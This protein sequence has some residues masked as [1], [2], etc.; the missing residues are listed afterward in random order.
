MCCISCCM[1]FYLLAEGC[2]VAGT[3]AHCVISSPPRKCCAFS[4][5]IVSRNPPRAPLEVGVLPHWLVVDG[6]QPAIPENAPVERP[7]ARKR[8]RKPAALP[9]AAGG[10][11]AAA[12][13]EPA[14]RKAGAEDVADDSIVRAP[15][16]HVLS[17]ASSQLLTNAMSRQM[18]RPDS[19]LDWGQPHLLACLG[20]TASASVS[21]LLL[22]RSFS[23]TST[24][25]RTCC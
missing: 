10:P 2:T 1:L 19:M 5:Q 9:A 11:R 8:P 21:N 14:P 22:H 12:A 23:C 25:C 4:L 6:V 7:H 16:K 15:V 13:A 24:R 18:M 3:A 20:V 17:Q